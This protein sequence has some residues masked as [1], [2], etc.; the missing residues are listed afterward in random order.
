MSA[1]LEQY[2]MAKEVFNNGHFWL[3]KYLIVIQK[4]ESSYLMETSRSWL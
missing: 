3:A 4:P 1:N 2:Q